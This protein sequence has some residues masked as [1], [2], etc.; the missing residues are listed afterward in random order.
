MEFMRYL[1]AGLPCAMVLF[2]FALNA[3]TRLSLQDS[4]DLALRSNHKIIVAKEDKTA[5][6]EIR[7]ASFTA[8]LPR[9]DAFGNYTRINERLRLR[10]NLHLPELL[11]GMA[12][13]NPGVT[14][15]PFYATMLAMVQ[16]GVL[17]NEI[18]ITAGEDNNYLFGVTLSQP[19]FTGGKITSQYRIAKDLEAVA[20]AKANLTRQE[21][22]A[23]TDL[24]Y[25]RVISLKEKLELARSYK[26]V[27]EKH[28]T[29]L[30]NAMEVGIATQNEML[31][32]EVKRK[33]AE[34]NV[35][36]AENGVKLAMMA[37]NQ[38]LGLDLDT[39]LVLTDSAAE[40]VMPCEADSSGVSG[41]IKRPELSML[42]KNADISRTMEKVALS[43]FMPSLALE[44]NAHLI[45]PNPYNNLETEF[46][47]DW[48][49]GIVAG[50]ELFHF[51]E[52]VHRLRAS[53]ANTRSSEQELAEAKDLIMLDIRQARNNYSESQSEVTL[54]FA[55]LEQAKENLRVCQERFEEGMLRSSELMDAQT[56]WQKAYSD[57]I[58]AKANRNVQ[59]T[60]YLKAIGRL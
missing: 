19:L 20:D 38:I 18:E 35:L 39:A 12:Q 47:S 25:W 28:A 11:A 57:W 32:A 2:A 43:D 51:G 10:E 7:K 37:L 15:D 6:T 14:S 42:A 26:E 56:L 13:A 58:D 22:I 33:E 29:D 16:Q 8:F 60:E 53:K 9:L 46:G 48:Q 4:R 55:G 24:A 5:A 50:M 27:V 59:A 54:S 34:L 3:E 52:R 41:E 45:D 44:L 30:Q 31:M 1:R 17:P 49:V 36:K 23:N 21:V 40:P